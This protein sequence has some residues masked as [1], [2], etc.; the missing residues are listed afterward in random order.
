MRL[1]SECG[2][3]PAAEEETRTTMRILSVIILSVSMVAFLFSLCVEEFTKVYRECR[4]GWRGMGGGI[5]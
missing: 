5:T 2:G 3:P 4:V 1:R